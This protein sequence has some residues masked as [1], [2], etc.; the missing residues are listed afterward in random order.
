MQVVLSTDGLKLYIYNKH[1]ENI[2]HTPTSKEELEHLL[3]KVDKL[4]L[5]Q[6]GPETTLNQ[7]IHLQCAY[8]DESNRWRHAS[9]PIII[10]SGS[11]CRFCWNLDKRIARYTDRQ[12]N[13]KKKRLVFSPRTK[14][15]LKSL[16]HKTR[17][18]RQKYSRAQKRVVKLK[19]KVQSLHEQI[20]RIEEETFD[21]K[22]NNYNLPH[23]QVSLR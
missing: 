17:V 16:L 15:K 8:K 12:R 9:C 23:N 20:D 4:L 3:V 13:L 7:N 22:L 21:I 1:L 18:E 5:C 11:I 6:G 14:K 19:Q 10:D 2:I